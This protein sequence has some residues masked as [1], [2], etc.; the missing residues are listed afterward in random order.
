MSNSNWK[1]RTSGI[2]LKDWTSDGYPLIDESNTLTN[3]L[4]R[5][6][7]LIDAYD[8]HTLYKWLDKYKLGKYCQSKTGRLPLELPSVNL[9]KRILKN[10][11]HWGFHY[12]KVRNYYV[13]RWTVK[14]P[15]ALS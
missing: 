5:S 15:Q 12:D 9:A 2:W 11:E 4:D 8:A 13:V 6:D 10:I 7:T 3:T 1:P 14:P